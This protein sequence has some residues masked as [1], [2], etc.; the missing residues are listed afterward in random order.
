MSDMRN[1]NSAQQ[2]QTQNRISGSAGSASQLKRTALELL[3]ASPTMADN[4]ANASTAVNS[5][6]NQSPAFGSFGDQAQSGFGGFGIN[7]SSIPTNILNPTKHP[8]HA[9]QDRVEQLEA[10]LE[11]ATGMDAVAIS[12]Q[13]TFARNELK[14]E[15][16]KVIEDELQSRNDTQRPPK[17]PVVVGQDEDGNDI[18]EPAPIYLSDYEELADTSLTRADLQL[19][20]AGPESDPRTI[21][22][23]TILAEDNGFENIAGGDSAISLGD[24]QMARLNV[25]SNVEEVAEPDDGL[26]ENYTPPEPLG[27]APGEDGYTISSTANQPEV[28]QEAFDAQQNAIEQAIK[29]G[30]EVSFVNGNGETVHVTVTPLQGNGAA[31]YS[32][33]VRENDRTSTVEIN[34]ELGTEDT[35]A[36]IAKIVDWGSSLDTK[37][38]HIPNFPEVINFRME[39][40]ESAAASYADRYEDQ[41]GTMNFFNGTTNINYSTYNHE[42]AHA[43]GYALHDPDPANDDYHSTPQ[44]W[45]DV[46]AGSSS[47]SPSVSDYG[48]NSNSGED[49]AESVA[50][51][52]LASKHGPEALAE[53][54][55]MYPD[56][57]TYIERY[58]L[59][60]E[61]MPPAGQPVMS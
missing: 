47:S 18:V 38:P 42:Q 6:F 16:L 11:T 57:S 48:P 50:A 3:A 20:A 30:E 8:I 1:V 10:K 46:I 41:P 15:S 28:G 22:A 14:Q 13:L 40:E 29:T 43:I 23:Q 5:L 44:G 37:G 55:E 60:T 54:R 45:E 25:E 2:T 24:I 61:P 4:L 19:L 27:A 31:S 21:A 35:I 36:S 56:R 49:F 34:S 51:Y 26:V 53:F 52:M 59:N 9:L 7:P 32:V 17:D 39:Y 33:Q 58:V 12:L